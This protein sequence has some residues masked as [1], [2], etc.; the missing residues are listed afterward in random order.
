MKLQKT[1]PKNCVWHN[2]AS[3]AF[4]FSFCFFARKQLLKCLLK[5][6]TMAVDESGYAVA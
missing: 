3:F 4:F 6:K 1:G 2:M 5:N